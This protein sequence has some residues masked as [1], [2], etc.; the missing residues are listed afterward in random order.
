[1]VECLKQQKITE[2]ICSMGSD[3]R[4]LLLP[5]TRPYGPVTYQRIAHWIKDLLAIV[6]IN[7]GVFKAHSVPV[8]NN[9]HVLHVTKRK[10]RLHDSMVMADPGIFA[11]IGTR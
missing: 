2:G 6:G 5:Y 8:S 7:T 9:D 11:S 10:P 3:V 1:V 4:P